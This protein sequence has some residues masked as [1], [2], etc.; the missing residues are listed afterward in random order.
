MFDTGPF[1]MRPTDQLGIALGRTHVNG[2]VAAA[3]EEQ[4]AAAFAPVGI[5]HSEYASEIYY[6]LHA[7]PGIYIQPNIQYIHDPGGIA[8]NKDVVISGL[9]FS[10]RL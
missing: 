3:E 8:K 6:K 9:K 4:N 1:D 7:M 5:Q 10:A 2:R